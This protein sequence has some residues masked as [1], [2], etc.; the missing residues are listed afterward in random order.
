MTWTQQKYW[1]LESLWEKYFAPESSSLPSS[2]LSFLRRQESQG[3]FVFR[4]NP[5]F[6]PSQNPVFFDENNLGHLGL[7]SYSYLIKNQKPIFL[8]DNHH[9]VLEP[10]FDIYQQTQKPLTVVHIDA[11]RDDAI[12]EHSVSE[13][14]ENLSR[15]KMRELIQKCR[16]SDY[17]DL[18]KKIGLIGKVIEVTQSSEFEDFQI[19]DE[20]YVLNLDIDIYGEEGDAVDFELKTKV[21]AES[22]G[23][24]NMVCCATSPGFIE[25]DIAKGVLEVFI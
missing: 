1:Q 25:R 7:D 15:E 3:K 2:F 23:N 18:G 19:P 4:E 9:E 22:W 20:N 8:C 13:K 24:A 10:F 6:T 12:F 17:L 5:D 14:I 21:I 11:H 16:V